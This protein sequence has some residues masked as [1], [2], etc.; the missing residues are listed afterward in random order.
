MNYAY[1]DRRSKRGLRRAMLKALALPGR[2]VP[3]VVPELPIAY[4]WGSAA[5]P[6][7]RPF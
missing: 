2:Q 5:W 7:R 1:L 4:G 3:F 6:Q